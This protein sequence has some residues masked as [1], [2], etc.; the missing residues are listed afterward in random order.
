MESKGSLSCSKE[1]ST[2]PPRC[3][4]Y[5]VAHAFNTNG[6]NQCSACISY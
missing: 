5:G 4:I 3:I 6:Q 1:P 2:G